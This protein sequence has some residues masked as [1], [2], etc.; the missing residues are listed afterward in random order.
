MQEIIDSKN[1]HHAYFLVGKTEEI[2]SE[3][4]D[5]LEKKLG[6]KTKGN[7]DFWHGK[8]DNFNIE[9]ARNLIE[10][11]SRK[12]F[13]PSPRSDLGLKVFVVETDFISH[14]AQSSLLKVFEEPTDHTHFFIISPQNILLP[15][16][17]SRM[18]VLVFGEDDEKTSSIL[19]LN[20]KERLEKVKEITEAISDEDSTKQDAIAFVNNIQSELYNK[21]IEKF[22]R[23][24]RIC[25]LTRQSLFQRGAPVKMI[26]ENLMLSI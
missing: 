10:N 20:L 23:E 14:E 19:K 5:F 15:T 4:F 8:F 6:V 26:L 11:S 13:N 7:P 3:F 21:G 9:E 2:L 22:S 17:L 24:L 16:L 1:L 12:G 25:E 18:Q